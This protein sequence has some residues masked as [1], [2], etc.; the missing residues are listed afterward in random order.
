MALQQ[1]RRALL[2]AIQARFEFAIPL[3]DRAA[4]F[5]ETVHHLVETVRQVTEFVAAR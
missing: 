2:L 1:I 4:L 5:A 3:L